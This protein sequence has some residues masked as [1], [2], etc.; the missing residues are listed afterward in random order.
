M[1]NPGDVLT[2]RNG[3]RLL[4]LQTAGSTGGELLEMEV[5]YRPGGSPPPEHYHLH[6]EER[7]EVLAGA[8]QTRIDG[9]ERT[10][11]AGEAFVVPRGA[12]HR[13]HN[14]SD[15]TGRLKWQTRP[16]LSTERFF[17]TLW[18]LAR[19]GKTN[20]N[21]VPNILQMAVI[22]RAYAREFRVSR[23]PH[24]VLTVLFALLTPLARLRGYKARYAQ[25]S[26][27]L[28]KDADS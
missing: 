22:G 7:F 25:Y 15:E 13:M 28:D 26:D 3:E 5:S 24:A 23:P 2:N 1:A 8:F 19:D 12:R 9:V 4:F 20:A 11:H 18:G 21:G 27:V 16:A 6:Q 17:E 14:V 10:Y